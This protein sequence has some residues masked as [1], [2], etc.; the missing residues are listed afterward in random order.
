[1]KTLSP[2]EQNILVVTLLLSAIMIGYRLGLMPLKRQIAGL[3]QQIM[4]ESLNVRKNR[5]LIEGQQGLDA[6]YELLIREFGQPG[7]EEQVMARILKEIENVAGDLN[8]QISDLK[9]QRARSL[10]HFKSFSVSLRMESALAE[11][12]EFLDI[13]QREP[14]RYA[15]QDVRF[16]KSTR[17]D[18]SEIKTVV[19]L[20]K[21]FIP[22][23]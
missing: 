14:Y 16:D 1:V 20:E 18:S 9:P 23:G 6:Q 7:A 13:L 5:R 12:V 22:P 21:I 3:E 8:L 17:R 2:R 15:V 4:A 11:I 19:I 10:D